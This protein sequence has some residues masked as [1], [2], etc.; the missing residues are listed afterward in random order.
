VKVL[1]TGG[2]GFLGKGIVKE[3]LRRKYTVRSFSR[4]HYPELDLLGVESL[5]GDLYNPT[6]VLRAVEGCDAVIH[7]AAKAGVWGDYK[8]YFE[9]NVSGTRNI[10]SACKALQVRKLIYTSSPSVVFNGR[11]Q[12]GIDE[13]AAIPKSFLAHYPST[14]ALAEKEVLSANSPEL[15]TV[16]L[17]PHLIWGPN[18]NH[19]IPRLIRMAKQNKLRFVGLEDKLVDSV[20]IDNAVD[21][22]IIALEKLSPTSV[23][24]GRA[25]FITNQEP[26]P[27]SYLINGILNAAKL[28]AVTRRIPAP[29][30]FGL[31]ALLEA[32]Y[33]VFS[34]PGEP[35]MTRFVARQLSTAHWYNDQAAKGCLGYTPKIS[36]A[37]G[38]KLLGNSL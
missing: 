22:H 32:I 8:E 4:N 10:L 36:L 35:R 25:F 16:S 30:A 21:A 1:V 6:A 27:M 38:L 13:S 19:L 18:D 20:Y 34:L 2:G 17:R 23:I 3:L 5:V 15:V 26:V 29:V 9:T 11:D 24:A 14:K 12:E 28:P 31:G 37:Q 33:S 7:T